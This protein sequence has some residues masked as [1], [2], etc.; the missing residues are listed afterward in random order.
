MFGTVCR[1]SRF[2]HGRAAHQCGELQGQ[3]DRAVERLAE[4]YLRRD[5]GN[6]VEGYAGAKFALLKCLDLY[7]GPELDEQVRRYVPHLDWIGDKPAA[8]R[9]K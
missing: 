6:P 2:R 8:P 4:H 3:G 9:T 5:Y 7:H 1:S